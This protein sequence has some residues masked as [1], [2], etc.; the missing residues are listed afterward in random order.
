M[1]AGNSESI[2]LTVKEWS[3]FA[4]IRFNLDPVRD[5]ERYLNSCEAAVE[6]TTAL[7]E[8]DAIP[9]IRRDFVAKNEHN[10]GQRKSRTEVL[11]DW[12]KAGKPIFRHPD[13][14]PYL[15]SMLVGPNLPASTIQAFLKITN[16][17]SKTPGQVKLNEL[18]KVARDEIRKHGLDPGKAAEEFYLLALET[19]LARH[20]RAIRDA[21]K[22]TACK[23]RR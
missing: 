13:F 16:G 20:A 23:K 3:I 15:K 6:L 18:R 1:S 21:A 9:Q 10:I 8:R 11:E 17:T 4:R 19:G 5:K 22:S 2:N 12:R 7:F 14:L